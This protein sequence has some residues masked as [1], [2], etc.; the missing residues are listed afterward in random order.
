MA[1]VSDAKAGLHAAGRGATVLQLRDPG[2]TARR[3][4][5]EARA[6][7][8]ATPLPVLVNARLDVALAAGAAGVHL[9]EHDL[10]VAEVRRV[11][12]DGVIGRSVHSLAA[13]VEAEWGGADYVV[14]GPVFST[15]THPDQLGVGL[16]ALHR[17]AARLRIP[18]IAIGGIDPSRE[19]A[20]HEAGAAGVAAIRYFS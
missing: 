14:F 18:V 13:A 20:C 15:P 10:P 16:D 11:L 4:E 1:I 7:V 19:R 2:A 12:P 3:L 17:V 6:L 5:E 8:P 9:P